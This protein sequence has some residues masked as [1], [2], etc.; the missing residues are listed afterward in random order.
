MQPG[1][2]ALLKGGDTIAGPLVCVGGISATHKTLYSSYG[3]GKALVS[4]G[5]GD[6]VRILDKSHVTV[7]NI[8]IVGASKTTNTGHGIDAAVTA[9]TRRADITISNCKVHG[10]GKNGINVEGRSGSYGF[11]GVTISG[12]EVYDC[13]ENWTPGTGSAGIMIS[14]VPGYGMK[15]HATTHTAVRVSN[16][17]VHDCNG[18]AGDSVNWT[19][20]GIFVGQ[21]GDW[22]IAD[23]YAHDCG[24][25]STSPSGPVAIWGADAINGGIRRNHAYRMHTGAGTTDGGGFDLD[26][27][28]QNCVV[29]YNYSEE[30]DGAG[31]LLYSYDD[32]TLLPFIN[33]T[34]RF[35]VSRQDGKVSNTKQAIVIGNDHNDALGFKNIRVYNNTVVISGATTVGLK[36]QGAYISQLTGFF[37]NN[38]VRAVTTGILCDVLPAA[39]F[40]IESNGW[41]SSGTVSMKYSGSNY[42]TAALWQAASGKEI[43]YS[44][45]QFMDLD[46]KLSNVSGTLASDMALAS[47]SPA[48]GAGMDIFLEFGVD[49]GTRD[50]AGNALR[51]SKKYFDLGAFELQA[52]PTN[53]VRSPETLPTSNDANWFSGS[54]NFF[55]LVDGQTDI[56]G[57]TTGQKM[58]PATG[59]PNASGPYQVID[60]TISQR[61]RVGGFSKAAGYNGHMIELWADDATNRGDDTFDV[62]TGDG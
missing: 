14:S 38:V 54:G 3:T 32:A 62:N 34:V 2:T 58:V 16:C 5:A 4:G 8:E 11:D 41:Y 45:Q 59:G 29:E 52:T 12:N 37:A 19:G 18:K 53:K 24:A 26:G 60:T 50:Y 10:F 25:N 13:T 22:E 44:A 55:S 6:G 47:N 15:T 33:N 61:T 30:C 46:P 31:Y 36:T 27:G 9:A 43:R 39:G 23:S 35:N 28:C 21:S 7:D 17:E 48:F 20:S 42:T 56:D 49:I 57:G 40:V 51:S 1:D